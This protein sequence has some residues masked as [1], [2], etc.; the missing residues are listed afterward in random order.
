MAFDLLSIPAM[1]AE[2]ERVFS[3][4]KLAVSSQRNAM[5]DVIL[6][7]IQCMKNWQNSG[8]IVM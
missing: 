4:A 3:Q 2:C 5:H 1:A 7:A 6:E 8:G